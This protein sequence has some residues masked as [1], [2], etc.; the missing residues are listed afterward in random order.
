MHCMNAPYP[1]VVR[2]RCM[3]EDIGDAGDGVVWCDV[4]VFIGMVLCTGWVGCWFDT[5]DKS[6]FP[7]TTYCLYSGIA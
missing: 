7:L 6:F 4:M 2:R 1:G 5:L 3:C